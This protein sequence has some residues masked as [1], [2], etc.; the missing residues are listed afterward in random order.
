M[1][2]PDAPD[3]M[4]AVAMSAAPAAPQRVLLA[5]DHVMFRQ[6]LRGLLEREGFNVVAEAGDGREAVLMTQAHDPDLAIL[7]LA[8]PLLDGPDAAEEIARIDPGIRTI[9]LTMHSEEPYIAKALQAGIKGYVLKSQ[10]TRD[11][12]DAIREVSQGRI[13]I[14][15][16]ITEVI[17]EAYQSRDKTAPG[18][19][20]PRERQVLKFVAEG[21]TTKEV[22]VLLGISAKTADSHRTRLMTKLGIHDTA[23]LVRYAIRQ[24]LIQA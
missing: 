22:G 12:M 13:Y 9:L 11:L 24:G 3:N 23:G 6:S 20:T 17:A 5:D 14:S 16:G 19:L 7:D 8:M 21:R 1:A 15:P 2:G 10:A 18:R 4:S